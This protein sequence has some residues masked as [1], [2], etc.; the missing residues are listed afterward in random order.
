MSLQ[1]EDL[2]V[3]PGSL[4][5]C[6]GGASCVVSS[7]EAPHLE[8]HLGHAVVVVGVACTQRRLVRLVRVGRMV[9]RAHGCWR[10]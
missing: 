1:L 5:T 9:Q 2:R 7:L 6:D 4:Q 10:S 3:K 8:T